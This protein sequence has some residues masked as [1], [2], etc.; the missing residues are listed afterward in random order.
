M[1]QPKASPPAPLLNPQPSDARL[2]IPSLGP[3]PGPSLPTQLSVA[4]LL[5]GPSATRL[6]M[7]SPS[8][9][10]APGLSRP[11]AG[12]S[13]PGQPSEARLLKEPSACLRS[14][15][16]CRP[17]S[18][19]LLLARSMTPFPRSMMLL[20]RSMMPLPWSMMLLPG[21]SRG[22]LR[23]AGKW[24]MLPLRVRK[25]C[26]GGRGRSWRVRGC[27]QGDARPVH[28]ATDDMASCKALVQV[29]DDEQWPA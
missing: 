18:P 13:L 2:S 12:P 15:P 19:K 9:S 1:R 29:C 17:L 16:H 11:S 6:L 27:M 23:S 7:G 26:H 28:A 25:S 22:G 5:M 3:A 24:L 4:R 8:L 14:V 21:G 20:A 10:R